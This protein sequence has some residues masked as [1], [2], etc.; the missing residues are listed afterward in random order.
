MILATALLG[1]ALSLSPVSATACAP[2][3]TPFVG[4]VCTPNDGKKHPAIILLGGS[5]GGDSQAKVAALFAD[6]GYV[7]A[8]AAYFGAPGTPAVLVNIPVETV[9]NALGALAK[10]DDVDAT[11]IAIMGGSKGGELALL[12]AATY[13][14]IKAVVAL[15]PSPFAY[16][17]LGQYNI[18]TGCSWTQNGK[19]LPC[20]PQDPKAGQAI[21]E[22]FLTHKPIVLRALYDASRAADP[23]VTAAATFHL[24]RIAGPVLCLAAA[25]DQMWNSQAQCDITMAYLRAHGHAF[26]DKA[27]TYPNAGHTFLSAAGGAK[28][29]ITSIPLPGGGSIE[30]GG[31]PDGDALAAQQALAQIYDFLAQALH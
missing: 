16:M 12:A 14:Q 4:T 19:P 23:A 11:R 3:T 5:E 24:E 26:A 18:P 8:S 10:R 2:V 13:R 7:A 15:V 9:G 28:Y 1:A 29:A 6:R 17:G 27:I 22:E 21:G 20:I 25:D 31:T 30:F